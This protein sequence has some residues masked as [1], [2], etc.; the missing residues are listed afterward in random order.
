M[1]RTVSSSYRDVMKLTMQSGRWFDDAD[2]RSGAPVFIVNETAARRYWPGTSPIG[3]RV[4]VARASQA[5]RSFGEFMSGTIVGVVRD[6]HQV[7][8]DVAPVA[9]VYVPYTLEPWGWGM[10]LVRADERALQAMREAVRQVDGR[11]IAETNRTPFA[12]MTDAV[13]SRLAPRVLAIRFM[14]AFAL[15]GIAL[16]CLGLYGVISHNVAQRTREIAV[17]KAM[18]A[19][20]AR[21][22]RLVFTD[23]AVMIIAGAV[24]GGAGAWAS[25]RWISSLLFE[26]SRL[27]P[28]VYAAATAALVFVAFLATMLPARRASVLDPA[29]A[30]RQE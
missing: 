19:T 29:T 5:A 9:E 14:A 30:L 20:N 26:T 1:Y 21:V 12:P 17:R 23:S 10:L 2:E 15:T 18:G 8:Q 16:A 28:A 24:V 25:T 22:L 13:S 4:R 27:D 11:L 6:V 3:A 7:S